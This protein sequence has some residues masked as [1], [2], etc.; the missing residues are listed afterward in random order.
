MVGE[1]LQLQLQLQR[2]QRAAGADDVVHRSAP[3]GGVPVT[4]VEATSATAEVG[5]SANGI[6][7]AVDVT[8]AVTV[9][10]EPST[11]ARAWNHQ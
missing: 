8:P 3:D 7:L 11:G 5:G 1:A 6:N 4:P 9:G 2:R 10:A